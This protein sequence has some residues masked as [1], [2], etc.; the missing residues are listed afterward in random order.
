MARHKEFDPDEAL[1]HARERFHQDGYAGSSMGHL[2]GDMGIRQGSF[3]ATFGSKKEL[4]HR[5]LDHYANEI[6]GQLV[7]WLRDEDGSL[8]RLA[9]LLVRAAGAYAADPA[10]RGCFLVSTVVELAPHDPQL[11]ASLRRY[12]E[13]LEKAILRALT[14][15]QQSGQLSSEQPPRTLARLM[16]AVMHG[17]AVRSK[18]DPRP[19]VL[20]DI[21]KASLGALR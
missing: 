2:L 3:Y 1:R 13:R 6:I 18:Y 9:G 12:W 10:H 14:V 20:R 17:L 8:D 19:E 4:F 16:L 11:A 15:A 7:R 5:A 21:A